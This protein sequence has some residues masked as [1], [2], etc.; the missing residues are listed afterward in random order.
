MDEKNT[1]AQRFLRQF[2]DEEKRNYCQDK[3]CQINHIKVQVTEKPSKGSYP[4]QVNRVLIIGIRPGAK[5]IKVEDGN[6]YWK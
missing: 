1:I 2:K 5:H 6:E 3:Y 4:Y